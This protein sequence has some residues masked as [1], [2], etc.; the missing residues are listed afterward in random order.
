M[1][2]GIAALAIQNATLEDSDKTANAQADLILCWTHM[3][4]GMFSYVFISFIPQQAK[5][6]FE[7][8]VGLVDNHEVEVR[9]EPGMKGLAEINIYSIKRNPNGSFRHVQRRIEY[10]N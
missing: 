4:K 5:R 10:S 7:K 2:S 8:K 6:G 1:P 9:T 3:S